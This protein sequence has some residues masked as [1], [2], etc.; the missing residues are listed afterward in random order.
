MVD[1]PEIRGDKLR[2][3]IQ[4][5]GLKDKYGGSFS[6]SELRQLAGY[7]RG[8]AIYDQVERSGFFTIIEKNISLNE[9]GKKY[10]ETKLIPSFQFIGSI[11]WFISILGIIILAE[12][13][14]PTFF[15]IYIF[16]DSPIPGLL[17]ILIGLFLKFGLLPLAYYL[18]YRRK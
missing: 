16:L 8:G 4:I 10:F 13:V 15:E 2:D 6:M 17:V 7:S 9:K 11:G 12:W 5:I 14:F 18:K 3:L 1:D